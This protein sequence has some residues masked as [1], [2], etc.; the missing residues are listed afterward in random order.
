MTILI[1]KTTED[2]KRYQEIIRK[3]ETE[4]LAPEVRDKLHTEAINLKILIDAQ[5]RQYLQQ[6]EQEIIKT[7][8]KA[9]MSDES[10]PK[11]EK[12]PL[13]KDQVAALE[14]ESF[15]YINE[16]T[17]GNVKVAV[18]LVGRLLAKFREQ[19][20]TAKQPTE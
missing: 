14:E 5:A 13:I 8:G 1:I 10:K 19:K 11:K 3:L 7:G 4:K 9:P 2:L 15:Q 20:E 12:Q 6:A 16:K 18:S 17:G